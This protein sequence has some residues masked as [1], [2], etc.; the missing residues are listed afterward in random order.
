MESKIESTY[1]N[2]CR[3]EFFFGVI[4]NFGLNDGWSHLGHISQN[5]Q[6]N[7]IIAKSVIK[8]IDDKLG[9]GNVL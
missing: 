8:I 4:G 5:R 6:Q 1:V 2:I 9:A 7:N 3:S